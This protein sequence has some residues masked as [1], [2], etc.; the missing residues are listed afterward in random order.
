MPDQE[1]AGLLWKAVLWPL[2]GFDDQGQPTEG[3]AVELDARWV[4]DQRE[5]LAPDGSVVAIDATVIVDRDIRIGSKMWQG[6]L[7]DLPGT[8]TAYLP[9][10]DVMEVVT[11]AKVPDAKG[12]TYYREVGL[13][14]SRDTL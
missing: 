8:G 10:T 2:S 1:T 6:S 9:D 7:D 12:R 14:R 4:Q 3:A 13:K 11:F 5:V